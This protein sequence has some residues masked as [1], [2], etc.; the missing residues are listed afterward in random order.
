MSEALYDR[1]LKELAGRAA[2]LGP[3][4]HADCTAEED[5]FLCGD[6]VTLAVRHA[7]GKVAE[8]GGRVRGCLLAQ[9]SAA[10]IGER[11]AG[12]T[13]DELRT[14]IDQVEALL[15]TGELPADTPWP[16]L[17]VF[18]PVHGHKHRHECVL[19]PFHALR[20]C[21]DGTDG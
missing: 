3:V 17:A 9:A 19:L 11:A 18:S 20:H 13:D 10:L 16:D 6:R 1:R 12:L 2:A 14:V 5:N 21:L 8:V 7:G 4:E 15:R